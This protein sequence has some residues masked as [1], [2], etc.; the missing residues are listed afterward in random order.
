LQTKPLDAEF[1]A[2]EAI[3][4][5]A[6]LLKQI[7]HLHSMGIDVLFGFGAQPDAKDSTHELAQAAQDG[8]GLPDRDYYTKTDE[9]SKKL[10]DQY[11]EHVAKML[12]LL[13]DDPKATAEHAK[14]IMAM[15]TALAQA[16]RTKVELRDPQKN[17]NKMKMA[18]LQ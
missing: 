14:K 17:Y 18:D 6:S 7:A 9:A 10:R 12:T 5:R 3:N 13:G 8:L 11:V 15:E 2:I 4:D 1:K 16:S